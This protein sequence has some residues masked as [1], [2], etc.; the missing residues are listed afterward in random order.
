MVL[1]SCNK[2]LETDKEQGLLPIPDKLVVLTFDDRSRGWFTFVAPLLQSYGFG[3]TFFVTEGLGYKNDPEFWIPWDEVYQLHEMG[4]EIGNHIATHPDFRS[5]SVEGIIAEMEV[6]EQLCQ[7]N[8]IPI[9]TTLAYP[10]GG[11]GSK[12]IEALD[13]KGYLFARCPTWAVGLYDPNQHHPYTI[14]KVGFMAPGTPLQDFID[15]VEP[16]R[17][18]KIAVLVFHGVPDYYPWVITPP[19][20]FAGYME[21]LHNEGYTVIALRD[22]VKY[23]DPGRRPEPLFP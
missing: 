17:D 12:C 8:G 6:I 23:V 18:G 20:D 5:L 1:S 21:Y 19:E 14:P 15:F 9:P 3:A 2:N 16:A 7:A 4:F 10:G 11:F 22:L 13:Q